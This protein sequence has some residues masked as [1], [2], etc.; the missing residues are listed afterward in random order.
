MDLVGAD[1]DRLD[2]YAAR[3]RHQPAFGR[4][5]LS[6]LARACAWKTQAASDLACDFASGFGYAF[7][8]FGRALADLGGPLEQVAQAAAGR[9]DATGCFASRLTQF[10][11]NFA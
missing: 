2:G 10:G 11:A 9:L 1:W 5:L 8:G 3:C 6:W 4:I 7:A